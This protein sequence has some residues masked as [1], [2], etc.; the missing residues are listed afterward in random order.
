LQRRRQPVQPEAQ[1][2]GGLAGPAHILGHAQ[3]VLQGGG[4]G[5]GESDAVIELADGQQPGIAGELA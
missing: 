4:E 2:P 3:D 5:S 1:S